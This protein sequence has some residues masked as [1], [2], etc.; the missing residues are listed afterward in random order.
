MKKILTASL[1]AMMAVSAANAEIASVDYVKSKTGTLEFT[2]SLQNQNLTQAIS[3]LQT[4]MGTI[5]GVEGGVV[6]GEK[7]EEAITGVTDK[8]GNV[9]EGKTVVDMIADAVTSAGTAADGKIETA[10][11]AYTDTEGMNSAI[12]TA[13]EAAITAAGTAADGKIETALNAYTDTEGMN[14]AIATAKEAAITAAGTAADGKIEALDVADAEVAGQYVSAVSEANGK[15]SVTRASLT[16]VA[17]MD[18]PTA[19]ENGTAT[20]ALVYDSTT[21]GLKW[22]SIVNQ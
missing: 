5:S 14:S 4:E 18:K 22:E 3:T 11:N 16:D 20:C 9:A 21:Q 17:K 7:L 15:I 13:K 2:G 19:C 10:L 8:I 1:V 12:A 6:S